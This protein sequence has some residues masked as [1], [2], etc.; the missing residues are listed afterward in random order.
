MSY[1]NCFNSCEV[2]A[3]SDAK[4]CLGDTETPK[5]G[6]E[7][8]KRETQRAKME[9]NEGIRCDISR[10]I[11]ID[12]DAPEI[13]DIICTDM[14]VCVNS[15][16]VSDGTV[17]VYGKA[18]FK[19]LYEAK[20]DNDT[21]YISLEQ[22]IPFESEIDVPCVESSWEATVSALCDSVTVGI[23]N[24]DYGEQRIFDISASVILGVT[25]VSNEK[26]TVITDMYS[27]NENILPTREKNRIYSL[28]DKYS[29]QAQYKDK[30]RL[31][32]R[33]ITEIVSNN[34]ELTFL[35]P[36]FSDGGTFLPAKGVLTVLGVKE[37]G[38]AEAQSAVVNRRIPIKNIPYEIFQNKIKW[39][40]NTYVCSYD[41]LL[42]SGELEISLATDGS[43]IALCEDMVDMIT[44]YEASDTCGKDAIRSG[45]SLYYPHKGESVWNV[46]KNHGVSYEKIKSENAITGSDFEKETPVILR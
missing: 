32:L 31:D 29:S 20:H 41:C 17:K 21:E 2:L 23:L 42:S 30:V 43:I 37:N 27:V 45:F 35:N 25:A 36:E 8:L 9:I 24:D 4:F 7:T 15:V 19:C 40:C 28:I 3:F 39:I 16:S 6:L 11:K 44:G 14:D 46:A 12:D 18:D 1:N 38:E 13:E 33:G 22:E 34:L 26:C 10:E 5:C